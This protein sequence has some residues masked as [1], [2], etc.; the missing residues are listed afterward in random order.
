[1][2]NEQIKTAY[3][4]FLW[5][6]WRDFRVVIMNSKPQVDRK[7]GHVLYKFTFAVPYKCDV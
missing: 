7:L 4:Q 3:K 2:S 6:E 5:I 1:M